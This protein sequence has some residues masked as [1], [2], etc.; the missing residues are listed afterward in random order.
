MMS[1]RNAMG[2]AKGFFNPK[3]NAVAATTIVLFFFFDATL[4][5]ARITLPWQTSDNLTVAEQ[6]RLV[7]RVA[8]PVPWWALG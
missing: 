8:G 3:P 2:G 6:G 4:L 7:L 1:L 5:R